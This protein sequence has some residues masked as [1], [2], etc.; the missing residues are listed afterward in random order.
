LR[1]QTKAKQGA[2][3]S[4]MREPLPDVPPLFRSDPDENF[5]LWMQNCFPGSSSLTREDAICKWL[6]TPLEARIQHSHNHRVEDARSHGAETAGTAPQKVINGPGSKEIPSGN[7]NGRVSG[8]SGLMGGNEEEPFADHFSFWKRDNSKLLLKFAKY[9]VL[10]LLMVSV[11]WVTRT[12]KVTSPTNALIAVAETVKA[13]AAI[14]P[15]VPVPQRQ[16]S[17]ETGNDF[18]GGPITIENVSV[19]CEDTQPCI[20]IRTRGNRAL[21]KLSTLSDPDRVV[22]DFEGAVSSLN[23]HRIAVRRGS[24]EAIRIGEDTAQ[25]PRTRLV[26]DLTEKCDYELRTLTNGVV[27]KVLPKAATRHAG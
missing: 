24:I 12:S 21:P 25:P 4:R 14:A 3:S 15:G 20:E 23:T 13:Q 27:L 8:N 11:F 26:I 10:G 19:G 22:M 16:K 2:G 7:T 5:S 1:R 18:A 6:K 17:I 9:S